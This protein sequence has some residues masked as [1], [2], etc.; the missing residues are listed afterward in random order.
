MSQMLH[1]MRKDLRRLRWLVALW[2]AVLAAR[3]LLVVN[4]A[5]AAVDSVSTGL[6][7][8]Q[9]WSSLEFV[10]LL[11]A[12]TIVAWLVLEE[13]LV[14]FTPFWLTRPYDAGSL[15]REKLLLALVLLVGMP[16]VA[17][18]VILAFFNTG[19]QMLLRAGVAATVVYASW[20]LSIMVLASL[21][22]SLGAFALTV[23]GVAAAATMLPAGLLGFATLWRA[24][25][26]GYTPSGPADATPGVVM[27]VVY[28]AAALS[29]VVYQ[30]R[31]RRRWV[32]VWLTVAGLAATVV[33]PM[34]WPFPFARSEQIRAGAWAS[35]V[36]VVHDPSWG[37]K[38][39]DV[40]NVSRQL[41]NS[42]RRV[43]AK[44][45]VSGVPQHVSVRSLGIRARLRFPD[46]STIESSDRGGF[47]SVFSARAAQAALGARLLVNPGFFEEGD[48]WTPMIMLTEQQ[49]LRH[50]GQ[51]G[52]LEATIDLITAQMREVGTLRLMPGASL[53]RG[54]SRL[55]I[56]AVQRA[57]DGRT[58]VIRQRNI[59]PLLSVGVTPETHYAVRRRSSG[60]ALMGGTENSW[61]VG[62]RPSAAIL[63]LGRPIAMMGGNILLAFTRNGF[64]VET[65]YHRFPGRGFGKAPP[66]DPSW[67][68]DA[69]LVVL[70]TESAGVV[71]KQ[72]VIENLV[73]PAN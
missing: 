37:T 28:L 15:L 47:G 14:G 64:T 1:I 52:R 32:A 45:T 38:L 70:Q 69:E 33:A 35:Q 6:L 67:F 2:L 73:V 39:T 11:L 19:P 26:P 49:F 59:Q 61:E 3:T 25:V 58:V 57:T 10:A 68:D 66:L 48:D 65:R 63:L 72:L 40:V 12:A 21:T 43:N 7:L 42:W 8:V 4:G 50:R 9:V 13:P 53:D 29:V 41:R 18:L 56:A 55:E 17:D 16:M 27:I 23:L 62:S 60:E 36:A 30:Y 54:G 5:A 51:T 34:I 20:A 46:G 44:L 24:D 71:S 31:H 22:P